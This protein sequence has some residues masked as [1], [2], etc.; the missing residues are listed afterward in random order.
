MIHELWGRLEAIV[1]TN[2]AMQEGQRSTAVNHTK[3]AQPRKRP[4]T[5]IERNCPPLSPSE[6][7][8]RVKQPSVP[9]K[10]ATATYSFQACPVTMIQLDP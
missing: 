8:A 9:P 4:Q 5:I 3:V 7:N 10:P 6:K 1:Q 2:F